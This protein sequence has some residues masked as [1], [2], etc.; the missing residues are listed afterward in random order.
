MP[1]FR[2]PSKA[3]VRRVMSHLGKKARGKPK[4]VTEAR[5]RQLAGARARRAEIRQFSAPLKKRGAKVA[6]DL[7]R[8]LLQGAGAGACTSANSNPIKE[9]L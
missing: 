7:V 1:T 5:L 4:R 3:E 2:T 8:G 6:S 9:S